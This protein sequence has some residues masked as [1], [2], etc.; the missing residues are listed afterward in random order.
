MGGN[1]YQRLSN[2]YPGSCWVKRGY[3]SKNNINRYDNGVPFILNF[4]RKC[5]RLTGK[6]L[7]PYFERWGFLRTVALQ[8]GDY[9]TYYQLMTP[10]MYVE[11][12][13]DMQQLVTDG[14]LEDID[15]ATVTAIS[16]SKDMWEV[17]FGTTPSIP[18]R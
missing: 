11:F 7:F 17:E 10:E 13:A 14:V 2:A 15:D 4:I 18:N 3:L 6:N 9:G 1:F 16:N 12:K 8:I 5:S